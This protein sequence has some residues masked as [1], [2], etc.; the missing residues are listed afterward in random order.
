M[1]KPGELLSFAEP[2]NDAAL[3]YTVLAPVNEAFEEAAAGLNIT[4]PELVSSP[5]LASILNNHLLAYPLTVS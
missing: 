1:S 4:L 5:D 3:A 2:F